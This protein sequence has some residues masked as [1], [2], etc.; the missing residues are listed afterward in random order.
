MKA[1]YIVHSLNDVNLLNE[2]DWIHMAKYHAEWSKKFYDVFVPYL[3][4]WN[5]N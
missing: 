1:S 2:N 3:R 5:K 4:E